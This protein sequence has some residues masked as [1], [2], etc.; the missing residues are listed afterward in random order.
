[1]IKIK[2]QMNFIS[3][4]STITRY[5]QSRMCNPESVL[6]H[7]A[8]VAMLSYFV[9]RTLFQSG[10]VVNFE[11]LILKALFH[12]SDE[13]ITGDIARP[14]KYHSKE[15]RELLSDME[16]ENVV[17]LSENLTESD[18]LHGVWSSAKDGPEGLIVKFCDSL[19]VVYKLREEVLERGNLTMS[20][21]ATNQLLDYLNQGISDIYLTYDI[22]ALEIDN[23]L[24]PI[25]NEC[26]KIIG[27]VRGAKNRS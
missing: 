24:I 20:H 4:L 2:D 3:Q 27:A 9:G 18:H 13:V 14:V 1:M 22:E 15:L 5:S 7:S 16:D 26:A 11:A 23:P 25:V 6:E 19:S 21:I 17:V 10:V 12:D 8:S